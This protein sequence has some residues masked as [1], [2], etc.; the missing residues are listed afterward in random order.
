MK[1]KEM[2]MKMELTQREMSEALSIPYNTYISYEYGYRNP[3]KF[4]QAHIDTIIAN[5]EIT[6]PRV[7]VSSVGNLI[8]KEENNENKNIGSIRGLAIRASK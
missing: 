2:R 7:R 3:S 5:M 4:A 8:K 1:L 6:K